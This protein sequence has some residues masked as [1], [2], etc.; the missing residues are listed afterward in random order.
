MMA[1]R[2]GPLTDLFA[3]VG[4]D[5]LTRMCR[6]GEEVLRSLSASWTWLHGKEQFDWP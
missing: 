3:L 4:P 1:V 2:L 6:L 5:A